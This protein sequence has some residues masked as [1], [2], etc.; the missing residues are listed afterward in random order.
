MR[1]A[2]HAIGYIWPLTPVLP[3]A[4][5]IYIH[6]QT[7]RRETIQ[8]YTSMASLPA[9]LTGL[10]DREGVIDAVYRAV[11]SFDRKDEALLRSAFTSDTVL[12]F[13][14]GTI[15]GIEALVGQ[16]FKH[17][18]ARLET[19]HTI[20]AM[21]VHIAPDGTTASATCNSVAMHILAGQGREPDHAYYQGGALSDF[22]MIKDTDGLWKIK[23]WL[24]QSVWS[25]GDRAA[26]MGF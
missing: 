5:A 17:F 19:T 7:G 3:A 25:A 22:E 21:R 14:Q 8:D 10:T 18:V 12:T 9:A 16:L 2:T 4:S 15:D 23:K 1:D 24:L 13:S 20:S 26:V 6:K 11:T